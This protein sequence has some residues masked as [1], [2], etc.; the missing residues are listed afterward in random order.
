MFADPPMPGKARSARWSSCPAAAVKRFR[1]RDALGSTL[2]FGL[3][4]RGASGKQQRLANVL[5]KNAS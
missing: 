1:E 3:T 2:P 4:G 5:R